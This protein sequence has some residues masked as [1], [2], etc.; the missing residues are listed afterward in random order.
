VKLTTAEMDSAPIVMVLALAR[1]DEWHIEVFDDDE[2][3]LVEGI[4]LPE[5]DH[6]SLI[7]Q[8]YDYTPHTAVGD[9]ATIDWDAVGRVHVP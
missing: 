8:P 2:T 4:V 5:S 7:V 6:R 9:P 3:L 1:D